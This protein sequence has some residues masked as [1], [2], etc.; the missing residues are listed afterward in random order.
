MY[1]F[2]T[3]PELRKYLNT[4]P[5]APGFV[6]TMGALHA[7][8]LSLIQ[9]ASRHH[10]EVVVSIFVNPTQFNNPSDYALYP[11]TQAQD[12]DLLLQSGATVLFMPSVEELY[13]EGL[14]LAKEYDLGALDSVLEGPKR[15]GHFQGVCHIVD[16]FLQIVQPHSLYMGE[17]DFQQCMVIKR[18]LRLNSSP[19]QLVICPTLREESGL[20]M[21]SRNLRL[22]AEARNKAAILY[23]CL[24]DSTTME[25]DS[26]WNTKQPFW[27]NEFR[28]A[29]LEP[30]YLELASAD[31]LQIAHE[32]HPDSDQVVLVAAWL[33]GV[34][35]I[36]NM[37]V[38]KPGA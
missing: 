17:K 8:H 35:L 38:K 15:P 33:E 24:L 22:N 13:P 19:V 18:M 29:G 5:S 31:D 14:K 21:S 12:I 2:K 37:R 34:R 28:K 1:I 4:R 11:V 10:D 23:Q 26:T 7:G 36:D 20:A 30:E 3:I 32:Y 6:P 27:Q 9:E 25:A 16:R